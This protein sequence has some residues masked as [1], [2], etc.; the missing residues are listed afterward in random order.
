M[1]TE[2][3]CVL[4]AAASRFVDP[5]CAPTVDAALRGFKEAVMTD[6]HQFAKFPEDYS[7]WKVGS[8]DPETGLLVGIVGVKIAMATDFTRG[9]GNQLE[10]EGT[11][12]G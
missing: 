12:N 7:L 4:D 1:M 2:L 5:F 6:G 8:F 3:F 9:F 11:N 10:L